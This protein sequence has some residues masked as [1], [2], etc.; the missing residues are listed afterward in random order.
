M[1]KLIAAIIFASLSTAAVHAEIFNYS[2][3]IDG[4]TYP[5]RVDDNKNVL[6]WRGADYSTTV[7]SFDEP[8]GCA[9][10]GWH[11]VGNGKSFTFCAATQGY[12]AIEGKDGNDV[13][14]CCERRGKC[15]LGK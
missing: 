2:C 3:K 8:N 12:A 4:K 14:D 11:A 10:A 13:A 1:A 5:L 7:A 6:A 9:N 15:N